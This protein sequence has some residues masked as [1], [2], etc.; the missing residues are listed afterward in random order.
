MLLHLLRCASGCMFQINDSHL[1]GDRG[2]YAS[3]R[4]VRQLLTAGLESLAQ[5]WNGNSATGKDVHVGAEFIIADSVDTQLELL[6]YESSE[7]DD[8]ANPRDLGEFVFSTSEQS[9]ADARLTTNITRCEVILDD[10]VEGK[11]GASGFFQR[12]ET[13]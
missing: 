8:I 12:L 2:G 1:L 10:K 3:G 6:E 13:D 4:G 7:Y 11:V 9:A 5:C